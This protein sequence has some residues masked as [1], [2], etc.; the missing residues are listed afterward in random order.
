[1]CFV[2]AGDSKMKKLQK[3]ICEAIIEHLDTENISVE[4]LQVLYQ[5]LVI[6]VASRPK[7]NTE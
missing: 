2:E 3:R 6:A 4:Y 5:I 7:N 1:M